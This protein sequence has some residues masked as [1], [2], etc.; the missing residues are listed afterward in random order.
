MSKYEATVFGTGIDV[1]STN[2]NVTTSLGSPH[3]VFGARQTGGTVGTL[4]V[5]GMKEELILQISGD[6]LNDGVIPLVP[7][8]LPIGATITSVY[9]DTET[10]FVLGGTTPTILIGTATSE[11]TNGLV[12]T[13]AQAQS[14]NTA[15]LTSSLTGTWA[16]N[17]PL[18]ARTK[19][20]VVLGGTLPT[21]DRLGKGR[22]TI[23]YVRPNVVVD[24]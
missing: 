15:V 5:D 8:Y 2:G 13:Q 19:I 10:V 20:N 9:W 12:I 6:V 7:T 24:D 1:G 16:V 4:Q 23:H 22:L 11:V 14:T 3:N 18:Q 17:T 21:S